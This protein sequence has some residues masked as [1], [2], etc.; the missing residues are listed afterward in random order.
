VETVR[1]WS[2]GGGHVPGVGGVV[3]AHVVGVAGAGPVRVGFG[4][5]AHAPLADLAPDAGPQRIRAVRGG[6][7]VGAVPGG[8]VLGAT[9]WAAS[10]VARSMMA[11]WLAAADQCQLLTSATGRWARGG[12]CGAARSPDTRCIS[13]SAA[14]RPP[15]RYSTRPGGRE[16]GRRPGRRSAGP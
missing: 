2:G 3:L 6:V 5:P 12:L 4:D 14:G 1:G 7:G 10:Q 15:R 13:G 16:A 9:F 8:G 11:G